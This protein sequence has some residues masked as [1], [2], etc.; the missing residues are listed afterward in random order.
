MFRGSDSG[1]TSKKQSAKPTINQS[2]E[3]ATPASAW[4]TTNPHHRFVILSRSPVS[5]NL[6][7]MADIVGIRRNEC[8]NILESS[9]DQGF[10]QMHGK[11]VQEKGLL[12]LQGAEAAMN[13]HTSDQAV[14][15]PFGELI[16]VGFPGGGSHLCG[17]LQTTNRIFH[18]RKLTRQINQSINR[19][20]DESTEAT[21]IPLT[22]AGSRSPK[23]TQPARPGPDPDSKNTT[24]GLRAKFRDCK[25][26]VS[27]KE[28]NW[29]TFCRKISN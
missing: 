1:A 15:D 25:S 3:R 10:W 13:E 7:L 26:Q 4:T 5:W 20:M 29:N 21:R 8:N 12:Q 28:E 9:Q 19:S 17:H 16:R 14:V 11:I 18:W 22:A 24:K 6:R 2:T 27:V 23:T